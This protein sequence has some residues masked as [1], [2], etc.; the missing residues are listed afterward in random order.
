MNTNTET[1]FQKIEAGEKSIADIFSDKYSFS[2]P[3]Y[4]RP[5]AWELPQVT[6]LLDDLKEAMKEGSG[7]QDLYFLG[8]IVLVKKPNSANAR[9]IDGQQRLTTLT[10][11]LSVLRDLT[12]DL[13]DKS[14]RDKYIIQKGDR[15]RKITDEFRLKLRPKDQ[16][17]FQN[18]VQTLDATNQ[19]P[20]LDGF[21]G[22]KARIVE[23]ASTLRDILNE[24]TEDERDNLISYLLNNCFLVVVSVPSDQA[25]RRIFTVLNAR[26]MDLTATDILKADLL[27]RA[28]EE[29]EV[30]LSSLWEDIERALDRKLFSDLF[31]HIRMIYQREKPRSSLEEGFPQYVTPFTQGPETFI[32]QTLVPF[33]DALLLIENGSEKIA[34]NFDQKTSD[35]INSLA[36]LDNKDWVP[37]LLLALKLKADGEELDIPTLVKKLERLAY[38]LFVTRTDVNGRIHRYADVMHDI[39]PETGHMPKTSGLEI[40]QSEAFEFFDALDGPIYRLSRVVK[41]ILLRL[42]QSLVDGSASYNYPVIT[43][44]HVCPQTI[45]LD[46]EWAKWFSVK[47]DH[48][49]WLHRIGNLVLLNRRKNSAASNWELKTKKEKYFADGNE[50][51]FK[52]TQ[53]VM[54]KEKWKPKT[55]QKRQQKVLRSLAKTW[56]LSEAF[57]AWNEKAGLA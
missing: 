17:F 6:A 10:I 18:S 49:Y 12:E 57:D 51:P 43:V 42:D 16:L 56:E 24:M 2:I 44:E 5:Y 37:P 39:S 22:S 30:D 25:A 50:T 46:S 45:S 28:S 15:D 34:K 29:R 53:Q 27:Q 36:R 1:Q 41:P 40:D 20:D 23:N 48:D 14:S 47:S 7:T 31:T 11:L 19:M 3:P 52:L 21:E 54:R 55:I 33:A 8:S 13:E 4:Q 38:F 32:S 9:V 26:G 35:L